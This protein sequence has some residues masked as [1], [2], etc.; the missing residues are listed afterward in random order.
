MAECNT[1]QGMLTTQNVHHVAGMLDRLLRGKAYTFVSA[2]ETDGFEPT[3]R[4]HQRLRAWPAITTYESASHAG[5]YVRDSSEVWGV[6]TELV[7][8]KF[9]REYKHPYLSFKPGSV[10]IT[11]RAP[12]GNKLFWVIAVEGEI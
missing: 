10:A 3:V 8:G 5:F 11:H 2:N 12:A 4:L 9:D 7:D 1:W 6:S